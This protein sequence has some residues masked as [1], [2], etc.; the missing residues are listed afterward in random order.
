MKKMFN[1][2]LTLTYFPAI[3]LQTFFHTKIDVNTTVN[4][5]GFC[6]GYSIWVSDY[7][8]ASDFIVTHLQ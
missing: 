5:T 1:A 2:S 8:I 6:E 3:P 4:V 7:D